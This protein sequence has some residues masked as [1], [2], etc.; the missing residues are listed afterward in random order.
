MTAAPLDLYAVNTSLSALSISLGQ[1]TT[2]CLEHDPGRVWWPLWKVLLI[3]AKIKCN[4]THLN[5]ALK[6]EQHI[7][8]E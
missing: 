5:S 7:P 3:G 8:W 4:P 1:P 6:K 2:L